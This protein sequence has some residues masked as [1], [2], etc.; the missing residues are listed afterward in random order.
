MPGGPYTLSS[1]TPHWPSPAGHRRPGA[2]G[3]CPPGGLGP[4]RPQHIGDRLPPLARAMPAHGPGA[5]MG[6][7]LGLVWSGLAGGQGDWPGWPWRRVHLPSVGPA[8]FRSWFRNGCPGPEG[9]LGGMRPGFQLDACRVLMPDV[10]LRVLVTLFQVGT[11]GRHVLFSGLA[12]AL[13]VLVSL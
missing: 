11:P 12:R 4:S 7:A 13:L 10:A 1:L 3:W 9:Q 2:N 5:F 6:Y 8:E